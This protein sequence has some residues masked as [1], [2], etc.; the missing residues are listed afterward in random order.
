MIH[1]L[2]ENPAWSAPLI[3]EL[4][5][6]RLPVTQ[7]NLAEGGFDLS[8]P[9]PA[10]VFFS[11]MSASAHTRGHRHSTDYAAAVLAWLE[12]H[13]RRVFNGSAVLRLELSKAAQYAALARAGI[14]VPRT[15]ATLGR[16]AALAAA[17]DLPAPFIAK[18]NRG[19]KGLSVRLCQSTDELAA[20][21]D[22]PA[23][24]PPVDGI[25]LLQQYIRAPAPFVTRVEFVDGHLL[26]AVRVDTSGGFELCPAEVCLTPQAAEAETFRILPDFDHPMVAAYQRFLAANDIAVAGIEFIVDADGRPFTYDINTNTNYNPL[27]EA[28]AGISGYAAVADMLQRALAPYADLAAAG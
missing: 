22:D 26:Y 5:R 9:P 28:K 2:F 11:R 25:W 7:W 17:A 21:L 19:G 4:G 3:T 15:V 12:D 16:D 24:E 13:G 10:G 23:T 6:R 8:R 18:H 14:A 20:Y 1:L 27:A